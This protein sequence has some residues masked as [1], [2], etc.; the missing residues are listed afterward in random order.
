MRKRSFNR[1]YGSHYILTVLPI[2]FTVIMLFII[3]AV[4]IYVLRDCFEGIPYNIAYS[5]IIGDVGLVCVVLIGATILKRVHQQKEYVIAFWRNISYHVFSLV[6]GAV[7][8]YCW[9]HSNPPIY[10]GDIY[11]VII[12]VP[13]LTYLGCTLL[14]IILTK[15]NKTAFTFTQVICFFTITCNFKTISSSFLVIS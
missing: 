8:S 10:W 5:A 15:G 14:P 9:W 13:L 7:V 2:W 12:V 3:T 6:I 4:P 1:V 11:H